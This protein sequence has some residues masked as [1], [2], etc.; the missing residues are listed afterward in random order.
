MR[1]NDSAAIIR[2]LL[3]ELDEADHIPGQGH[4]P[5]QEYRARRLAR[6]AATTRAKTFLGDFPTA[7]SCDCDD[8]RA[9]AGFVG[10]SGDEA[11]KL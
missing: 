1:V 8:C 2:E 9:T 10:P 3:E 4:G 11:T 7:G 6:E 5:A